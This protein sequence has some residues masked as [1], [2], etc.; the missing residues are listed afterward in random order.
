MLSST[1]EPF[2]STKRPVIAAVEV[3]AVVEAAAS[4]RA[5][6]ATMNKVE[7]AAT[8]GVEDHMGEVSKATAVSKAM[9]G[10]VAVVNGEGEE[11]AIRTTPTEVEAAH[12]EA[13]SR[14]AAT[15]AEVAKEMV[16]TKEVGSRA[17]NRDTKV[18]QSS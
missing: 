6:V 12:M 5:V 3:V 14:E 9:A 18:V 2:A 11:G 8:A 17:A 10:P 15:K 4:D 1:A 16:N 7:V 13:D